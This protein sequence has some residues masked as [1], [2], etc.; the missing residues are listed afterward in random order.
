MQAVAAR[1]TNELLGG[2]DDLFYI[3]GDHLSIGL[4][5]AWAAPLCPRPLPAA[6]SSAALP[7]TTPL[8]IGA[9]NPPLTSLTEALSGMSATTPAPMISA[10]ST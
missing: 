10:S 1:L 5:Q 3:Y 4:A 2:N 7:V 9:P 8:A 6:W